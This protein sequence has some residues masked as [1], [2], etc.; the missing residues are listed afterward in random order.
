MAAKIKSKQKKRNNKDRKTENV[1]I[2]GV[3]IIVLALISFSSIFLTEQTGFLGG[4]LKQVL[5]L[6]AGDKA[7]V[8]PLFLIVIGGFALV[9]RNMD[10]SSRFIG[11]GIILSLIIIGSHLEIILKSD[12][13]S[14]GEIIS[15]SWG[16]IVQREGGG[17]I[18]GVF[19]TLFLLTLGE[20]GTLIILASGGFLSFLLLTNTT[21]EQLGDYTKRFLFASWY[22]LQSLKNSLLYLKTLLTERRAN[23][24]TESREEL[25]NDTPAKEKYDDNVIEMEN[26]KKD[27]GGL[28]ENLEE[29]NEKAEDNDTEI[30]TEVPVYD[31][32]AIKGKNSEKKENNED[33]KEDKSE[34]FQ[35]VYSLNNENSDK[36]EFDDYKLPDLELLKQF[37]K[38]VSEM[39]NKKDLNDKAQLL[40]KTLESF[41]VKAKVSKIQRGPTVNR[42]ELQPAPGIKVSKIVN[43]ADDIA[44]S[45]AASDIRIEAPIPGKSAVGVEVPNDVVSVVYIRDVLESEKFQES[46]SALTLAI[47]KDI[48]GEPVVVDLSKM[49]HLLIAGATGA[50]K[51][52]C[53]N[54]LITSI[55]YKA[56][57]DE[58]K[59]L[60]VDPK[61]VELKSFDGLPH[62][63]APVVTDPKQAA[64]ALKNIVKEMEARYRLFAEADVRDIK[65]YNKKLSQQGEKELPYIVVIIDELADLMMVAPTEVEDAIFRLAQM[66]RA[67]GIHLIVAT[68]RPSVDVITG[69]IK[70]NIT[71]RIAFAV[72]SQT[73]SRTILDSSGAEKLLG[74][75]D[76]L[77]SPVN[78]NK[79]IRIQGAFIS[80]DEVSILADK[81]KE[82]ASP[83]YK[84]ELIENGNDENESVDN[85]QNDEDELL[86]DAIKL[87]LET[88]QASISLIQRRFRVGYTRAAR[89]IDEMEKR[90]VV[91]GFEGSKPRKILLSKEQINN[92]IEE[93][94]KEESDLNTNNKN[95]DEKSNNNKKNQSKHDTHITEK[96]NYEKK[97]SDNDGENKSR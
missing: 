87:V 93:R 34:S 29:D 36:D 6:M 85:S 86:E 63:I 14:R 2:K 42:Y 31:F 94:E 68:Q 43:L 8:I 53:I 67:A 72:S 12:F 41:G 84:E 7:W 81:I 95:D 65:G 19:S 23:N 51:S 38:T 24:E 82:Q 49:P 1:E 4:M 47:G 46:M 28:E 90:G 78:S 62:L 50:G 83:E 52:V 59:F 18:G 69:V 80:D 74:E 26:Y 96:E 66:S 76:M 88:K 71:S 48:T 13:M 17:I 39:S 77:Y 40:V 61:V 89:L 75:G 15:E 20:I 21:F 3:G 45:L 64:S 33:N 32:E 79:A 44:L 56:K 73:D 10:M 60:L 92:Y 16:L 91:G 30:H 55:L 27:Q 11:F 9:K 54:T 70:S 57:P 37:P 5:T 97:D 35:T 25:T 58:V 22:K